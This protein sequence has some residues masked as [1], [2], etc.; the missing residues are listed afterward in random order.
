VHAVA[1]RG[2][3]VIA[4]DHDRAAGGVR[5]DQLEDRDG[6]RAVADEVAEERVALSTQGARVIEARGERLEVAVDVGEKR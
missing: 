5:F 3:V 1:E 6:V 4:E 2:R